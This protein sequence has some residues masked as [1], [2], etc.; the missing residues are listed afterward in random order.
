MG[1]I[2]V[3]TGNT[4][5]GKTTLARILSQSG[6][7][8]LA[9]EQHAERP[10]Q[11]LF[12]ADPHYAL[13]NQVDYLLLRAEQE[14]VLRQSPQPGLVDGGLDQDFHGFTRLFHA[15]GLLTDAEFDLCRRFYAFCRAE[16]PLPD[17]IIHLSAN[18]DV[19]RTRL[20][21][22]ER[23]N[24]ATPED[25]TLLASFLDEWLASLPPERI[26]RLDVSSATLPYAEVIPGL[27]SQIRARLGLDAGTY[28]TGYIP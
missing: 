22:R 28:E 18:A 20:A 21:G 24:V 8:N 25:L 3:L 4:G 9:L 26:L 16:L 12:K 15:R 27:L 13:A 1:K 14:R 11:A 5:V 17:L 6:C 7:L 2:I 19:L 10:F 23:I